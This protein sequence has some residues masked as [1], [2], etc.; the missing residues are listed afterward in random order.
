MTGTI[1]SGSSDAYDRFMGRYSRPLARA[2]ADFADVTSGMRVLDVGAGTGALADEL[3]ARGSTVS[4]VEP[5]PDYAAGLRERIAEVHVAPAEEMPLPDGEFDAVLAQLVVVFLNDAGAAVR[6]MARVAREGGVVATC[7]WE[8]QGMDM[9]NALNMVRDRIVPGT[10]PPPS[11][12]YRD[13][14][15]LRR[16]FESSSLRNVE[17]TTLEVEVTYETID[18]LW[19]PAI[20][21]GGPGGPVVDR[22]TPEQLAAGRAMFEEALGSPAGAYALKGRA[23]AVRGVSG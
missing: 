7:M 17:T 21:V 23:A 6:E 3:A 19:E 22:M 20:H 2:F 5:S 10:S 11:T 14:A 16:L 18:E 1:F 15:S 9:M 12:E 13:E 8:V 4:A